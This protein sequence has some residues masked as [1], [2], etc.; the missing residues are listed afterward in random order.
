MRFEYRIEHH[1][2]GRR[3]RR[4]NRRCRRRRDDC[5]QRR[6]GLESREVRVEVRVEIGVDLRRCDFL[7]RIHVRLRREVH[8]DET[9]GPLTRLRFGKHRCRLAPRRLGGLLLDHD[10]LLVERFPLL[11]RQLAAAAFAEVS[12]G[13]RFDLAFV[14]A[15]DTSLGIRSHEPTQ[16]D[17]G[18]QG[19][20]QGTPGFVHALLLVISPVPLVTLCRTDN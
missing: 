18:S 15:H 17:R 19:P 8:T 9:I 1:G 3:Q 7:H 11:Q 5:R 10:G 16:L 14:A 20:C 6:S 13:H 4:S 12:W 2:R